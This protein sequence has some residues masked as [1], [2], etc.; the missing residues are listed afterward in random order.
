MGV[1]HS[2]AVIH[3]HLGTGARLVSAAIH[4][5]MTFIQKYVFS[6]CLKRR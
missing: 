5:K 2:Q 4:Q 1:H 3:I 6:S